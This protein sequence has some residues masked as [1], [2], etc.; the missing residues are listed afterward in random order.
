MTGPPFEYSPLP[1]RP[2]LEWPEGARVAVWVGVNVEHYAIDK[3]S[4]SIVAAHR[5]PRARPGQLRLARLRNA[6]RDLA[7]GRRARPPWDAHLRAGQRRGLRAVPRARRGGSSARV[8][9][10]RPRPRQLHLPDRDGARRG[11][12]LPAAHDGDD[13]DGHRDARR[14]DG[15][16]RRSRRPSK[17]RRSWRSS[18][19]TTCATGA[20]TTSPTRCASRAAG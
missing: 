5:R 6:R 14:A 9:L 8:D 20:T 12:R 2:P 19:T 17:R 10:A 4:I 15:S 11:A 3:P 7:A 1:R 13:R 16:V 18:A